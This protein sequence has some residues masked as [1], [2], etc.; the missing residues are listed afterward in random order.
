MRNEVER[1]S[2]GKFY[3]EWKEY[4]KTGKAIFGDRWHD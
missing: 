4:E 3:A 1:F 2:N